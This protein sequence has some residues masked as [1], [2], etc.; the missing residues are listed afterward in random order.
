[1]KKNYKLIKFLNSV[2]TFKTLSRYSENLEKIFNKKCLQGL[3]TSLKKE[4]IITDEDVFN[5]KFEAIDSLEQEENHANKDDV[6]HNQKN[7]LEYN[8]EDFLER[9]NE[10]KEK[11][12]KKHIEPW[13][14]NEKTPR[15]PD[16]KKIFDSYKYHPNYNIIYKRVPSF[17]FVKSAKGK[18]ENNKI[19]NVNTETKL[20]IKPVKSRN[21]KN[22]RNIK[23]NKIL[24]I[25]TTTNI[26]FKNKK[27][28]YLPFLTSVNL[29]NS[30]KK[31]NLK[32]ENSCKSYNKSNPPF[33]SSQYSPIK[34][35]S[36]NKTNNKN[37]KY[38]NLKA[39]NYFN[40]KANIVNYKK[41]LSRNQKKSIYDYMNTTPSMWLYNP[42]YTY[43]EPNI[44]KISFDPKAFKKTKKYKKLKIMK[45]IMTAYNLSSD[46]LSV[47]NSKLPDTGFITKYLN[48]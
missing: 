23:I 46:Y 24:K 40:S 1:M 20:N 16:V 28:K 39:Y 41:M 42:K 27:Q 15:I 45:R 44:R 32:K 30:K 6:N 13:S 2:G 10:L 3:I 36:N 25:K 14:I 38:S 43:I 21:I 37:T 11:N 7:L 17:T 26:K 29:N 48:A 19:I 4:K 33:N 12:K 35:I 9:Q 8:Y 22:I 31:D 18:K 34:S 47:D 5:R